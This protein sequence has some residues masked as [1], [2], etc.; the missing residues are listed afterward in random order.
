ME[1]SV[2]WAAA[3]AVATVGGSLIAACLMPFV[4]LAA[5]A[6]STL[7]RREGVA[8]MLIAWAANQG[9]GFTLLGYPRDA[10]TLGWGVAIGVAALAAYAAIRAITARSHGLLPLLGGA[11]LGF[12]AYELVLYAYGLAG[13]GTGAFT[14]AIVALLAKNEALWLAGLLAVRGAVLRLAP[15]W[16]PTARAAV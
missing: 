6:A 2:A 9:I 16:S 10:G 15:G 12:V 4:A 11:A 3:L 8:T 7:P 5:M 14:Q 13:G 1:R